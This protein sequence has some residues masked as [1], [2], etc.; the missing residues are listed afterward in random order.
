M[1]IASQ[2]TTTLNTGIGESASRSNDRDTRSAPLV[3]VIVLNW[4]G[5][6]VLTEC[7]QALSVQTYPHYEILV[8]DN[9]STDG[10]AALV[11]E[12]FPQ[13]RVIALPENVGFGAGN[14]IGYRHAQG[15]YIALLNNDT[16]VAQQWLAALCD[17]LERYPAAG[18]AASKIVFYD[19]PDWIDT[20]GD[21][22]FSIGIARKRG[23]LL[24]GQ[25]NFDQETFIFGACAGAALYRRAML[26]AIGFFDEDF[27]IYDDD[28]DLSFRAQ[29]ANWKCVYVPTALVRHHVSA[30]MSKQSQRSMYLIKRNTFWVLLKNIPTA[31]W[32]RYGFFILGY[33]L[34]SDLHAATQGYAGAILRG[35]LDALR[36][37]SQVQSKRAQIQKMRCVSIAELDQIFSHGLPSRVGR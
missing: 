10:S 12:R 9:G 33:H 5:R 7:L 21:E 23:H 30:T 27:E 34:L 17:A 15:E 8:V 32:W 2:P 18:S 35:R 19:Q 4:N 26:D 11:R 37:W 22:F 16:C 20:A 28:V 3:S 31:L 14:N 13:V 36:A 6:D 29:L 25:G 1:P 24:P